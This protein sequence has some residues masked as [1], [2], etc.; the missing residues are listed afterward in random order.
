MKIRKLRTKRFI[1]LVPGRIQSKD[2]MREPK[3]CLGQVFNYKL[4]CLDDVHVLIY[5]V[6]YL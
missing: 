1:T 6:A 2:N 3:T 4:G 5:A